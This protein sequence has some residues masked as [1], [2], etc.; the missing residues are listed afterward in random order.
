MNQARQARQA[1][2]RA[3]ARLRERAGQG[4]SPG[5]LAADVDRFELTARDFSRRTAAVADAVGDGEQPE[6]F[7]LE[8]R[9]LRLRCEQMLETIQRLRGDDSTSWLAHLNHLLQSPSERA[10]QP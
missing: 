6:P 3:A 9:S 4:L 5:E 7:T 1:A 10:R 8:L 2:E